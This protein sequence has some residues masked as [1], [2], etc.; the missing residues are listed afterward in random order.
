MK[1]LELE[2]I[3]CCQSNN[4]EKVQAC[5]TLEVD[6]NAVDYYGHTAAHKAAAA[7]HSEVIQIL[8]ATDLVDWEKGDCLGWT[9]LHAALFCGQFDVAEIIAKQDNVNFSL[10]CKAGRTVAWAAVRG[11]SLRCVKILAELE[12][13]DSWNIPNNEGVTPLMK[14]ISR[15]LEDILKILLDCPLVDTNL[16]DEDGNSPLMKAIKQ[17]KSVM[18]IMMIKCP[19]MDLRTRDLQDLHRTAR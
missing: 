15:N 1:D 10:K 13:C 8:A 14:A 17:E 7:G 3:K 9:P 6:V 12:N 4:L 16:K 11:G 18:A 5:L 19:R 2:F